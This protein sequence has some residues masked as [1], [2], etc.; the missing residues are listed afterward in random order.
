[1]RSY[2]EITHFADFP[3]HVRWKMHEPREFA[4]FLPDY[5]R[6]RESQSARERGIRSCCE[7]LNLSIPQRRQPFPILTALWRSSEND[8]RVH[9]A[10]TLFRR[11]KP[12]LIPEA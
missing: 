6:S 7:I 8:G 3:R 2:V 11:K 4:E 12:T 1:M 10:S 9:A 5:F